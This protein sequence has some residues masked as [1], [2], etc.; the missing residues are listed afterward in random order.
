MQ[1]NTDAI[2]LQGSDHQVCEDY[3]TNFGSKERSNRIILCDGCSSSPMTDVGARLLALIAS[4]SINLSWNS[5]VVF[6]FL[7]WIVEKDYGD[8]LRMNPFMFDATLLFAFE[9]KDKINLGMYGDGICI[10]KYKD[11]CMTVYDR[12]FENNY[13]NYFSYQLNQKRKEDY[14][15]IDENC[16]ISIFGFENNDFN[17][18]ESFKNPLDY[19]HLPLV[20]SQ[21]EWLLLMSDGIHSFYKINEQGKREYIDFLEI[22]KKLIDFKNYHGIFI[23][24][25]V[26]SLMKQLKKENIFHYDDFSV[27]GMYVKEN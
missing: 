5:E 4:Q 20:K 9:K 12:S 15:K 17:F 14:L 1:I 7:K 6:G 27:A 11:N 8:F 21:V 16:F 26:K 25:Q 18:I 24:R 13:P 3:A 19:Y 2:F 23:Q 22:I 10:I